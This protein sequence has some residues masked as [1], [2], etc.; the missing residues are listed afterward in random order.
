MTDALMISTALSRYFL[1]SVKL[2]SRTKFPT[3]DELALGSAPSWATNIK[4]KLR[5]IVGGKVFSKLVLHQ[6]YAISAFCSME[7]LLGRRK[8]NSP[9]HSREEEDK[10]APF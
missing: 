3:D 7:V 1:S 10:T 6:A 8:V 9:P 5:H 2:L 4:I